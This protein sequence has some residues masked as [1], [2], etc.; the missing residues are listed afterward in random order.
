MLTGNH[1]FNRIESGLRMPS[2]EERASDLEGGGTALLCS[3][4]AATAA[5]EETD[6][7]PNYPQ[8]ETL[9][10]LVGQPRLQLTLR[11]PSK[12][13]RPQISFHSGLAPAA[14]TAGHQSECLS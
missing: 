6:L 1:K 7:L 14:V 4:L 3:R 11:G 2:T 8:K 9:R 5:L 10:S 13:P 12:L